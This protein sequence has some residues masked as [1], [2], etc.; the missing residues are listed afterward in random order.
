MNLRAWRAR[1][2][3]ART[4]PS[5]LEVKLRRATLMDLAANGEIPST[6]DALVQKAAEGGFGIA[7]VQEFMPLV[8]V[9]VRAC[10][11]EPQLADAPDDEHLTLSEIPAQDRIDIFMWANGAANALQSFRDES[12]GDV[13]GASAG[14]G[15]S[16]PAE[17]HPQ[18]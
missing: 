12:A 14:E 4:L 17:Q 10:L 7:E 16:Q 18:H 5:G 6:L 9:V 3:E 1:Q 13:A 8:N 11:V 2:I 15:V